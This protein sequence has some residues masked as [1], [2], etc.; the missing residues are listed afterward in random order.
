MTEI[1][2]DLRTKI[3]EVL[4]RWNMPTRQAAISAILSLIAEEVEGVIGQDDI[5]PVII[6]QAGMGGMIINNWQSRNNLRAQQ[7]KL[8]KEKGV[9]R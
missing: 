5:D 6:E 7:R 1:E 2:K 4:V 8:A 9:G 3:S